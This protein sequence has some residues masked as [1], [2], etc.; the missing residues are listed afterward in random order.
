MRNLKSDC[1]SSLASDA[2]L[3][4]RLPITAGD[5]HELGSI[6]HP[7]LPRHLH[8]NYQHWQWLSR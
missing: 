3:R 4:D 2:S 1:S 5:R 7:A 6:R 8:P